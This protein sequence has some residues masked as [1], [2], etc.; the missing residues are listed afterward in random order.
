MYINELMF[1][2]IISP[3]KFDPERKREIGEFK[4][5]KDMKNV[6][7]IYFQASRKLNTI[8]DFR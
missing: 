2:V 6:S 5:T 1:F 4:L 7:A 3:I 8:R